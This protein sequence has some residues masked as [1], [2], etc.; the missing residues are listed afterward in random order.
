MLS[1]S[2]KCVWDQPGIGGI[3]HGDSRG[4][5]VELQPYGTPGRGIEYGIVQLHGV[6]QRTLQ[7]DGDDHTIGRRVV[8]ASG[9]DV[10]RVIGGTDVYGHAHGRRSGDAHASQQRRALKPRCID[11]RNAS[12]RAD[13]RN[14]D[15]RKWVGIGALYGTGVDGRIG[16]YYLYGGM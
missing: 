2:D 5:G 11:L 14:R 1:D 9:A 7:R 6:A 13:Y 4:L 8:D 10:Q 15:A 16:Y 12:G 3:Q